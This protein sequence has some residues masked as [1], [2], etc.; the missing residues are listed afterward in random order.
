MGETENLFL[1]ASENSCESYPCES[2]FPKSVLI[3]PG[4][5]V[6]QFYMNKKRFAL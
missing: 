1:K 2:F 5:E 6:V 4:K 3:D